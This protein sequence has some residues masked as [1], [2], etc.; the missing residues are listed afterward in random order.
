MP[1][2]LHSGIGEWLA[3]ADPDPDHTRKWWD[4]TQVVLLPLGRRWDAVKV[5]S[6]HGI[7]AVR[8]GS[9]EGP[10]IHDPDRDAYFLV[11]VGTAAAWVRVGGDECLGDTCYLT[12]PAPGRTG[13]PGVHWLQPPVEAGRLVD[14][15]QLAATLRAMRG[16]R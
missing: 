9:I 10:V 2:A 12:I 5:S 8:Q 7:E 6:A 14:P 11:P 16:T 3:T 15:V 1:T 4:A 13:P